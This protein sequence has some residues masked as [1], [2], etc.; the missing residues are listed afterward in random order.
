MAAFEY[1]AVD[2][3]GRRTRGVI[4]AETARAAR[5]ELQR[6]KLMLL[7][8]SPAAERRGGLSLGALLNR[9]GRLG[10]GELVLATR[11][12]A[13]LFSAATP[14]EEALGAVALQSESAAARRTLLSVRDRVVEGRRLSEAM[15]LEGEA[16]SP[17]YR[18]MVSAGEAAGA[19]GPVMERLADYL[20]R[21]Q[22]MRRK[23]AA[24][25]VYPT[26]LFV[27]AIAV[28][29]ALMA[30]V[31]PRVVDQF[32]S[33]GQ[34]LPLLTRILIGVSEGL[35]D[36]GW[37]VALA[38]AAAILGFLRALRQE[39][40]RRG[41][42]RFVLRLPVVGRM[43]RDMA[44]A[45]FARTFAAL[46]AS[47]ATVMDALK[48]ARA[49]APN[50]VIRDAVEAAA[51]DVQEGGSL[52][53]ALRKTGAFPPLVV[54]MAAS[55]EGGGELDAMFGKAADYLEN[56]FE[57]ATQMALNLLEPAII[58]LMGG[59]VTLIILAIMLPIL[60]LNSAVLF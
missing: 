43:A 58:V 24:A 37:L 20:E 56:E 51:E 45:R 59:L 39:G 33:I 40:F 60:Q 22:A 3:A 53:A 34:E 15:S 13:L 21:A 41:F 19:L 10:Q 4:S 2:D 5:R 31:V 1:V 6:R 9:G 49:T 48:A 52:S 47:G 54:H 55:G 17:L 30:F 18:S 38:L 57:T 29:T 50:M 44:A 16:F 36:W 42:D 12:L 35:R 14:V 26:V 8:L 7:K 25:L 28:V 23:T 11:Q 46:I 27:V 32:S